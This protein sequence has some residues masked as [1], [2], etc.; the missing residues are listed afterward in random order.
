M[1]RAL[2][3]IAA[4]ALASQ[5]FAQI[6]LGDTSFTNPVGSVD[7]FRYI[8]NG[9][10]SDPG[11]N[12][13]ENMR[14]ERPNGFIWWLQALQFNMT[15][16]VRVIEHI[17][18]TGYDYANRT[19]DTL[20]HRT[21]GTVTNFVQMTY[22]PEYL[23]THVATGAD[24]GINEYGINIP[25]PFGA[26]LSTLPGGT[27]TDSIMIPAQTSMYYSTTV[28]SALE[29]RIKLK[30]FPTTIPTTINNSWQDTIHGTLRYAVAGYVDTPIHIKTEVVETK[31]YVGYGKLKFRKP[32]YMTPTFTD[33]LEVLQV[34]CSLQ[35]KDFY[36]IGDNPA[37]STT[38]S[39]LGVQGQGTTRLYYYDEYYRREGV[40]PVLT[41]RFTDVTFQIATFNQ[42]D[43][44]LRH[45]NPTEVATIKSL[46][47]IS[48]YP[49]PVKGGAVTVAGVDT[50]WNYT[51]YNI[52]GQVLLSGSVD[53]ANNKVQLPANIAAGTYF[54]SL[55]NENESVVKT[56]TIAE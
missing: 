44:N 52:N 36:Y 45:L 39:F 35:V 17:A 27:A 54:M 38:L 56:L 9:Y 30:F 24:A 51:L 53:K 55:E 26:S 18:A 5:G 16:P 20:N 3:S 46:S 50:K 19:M 43:A 48:V 22:M 2:L 23:T 33:T 14:L 47:N 7:S 40:E 6:T 12:H 34:R 13:P 4:I 29:N 37:D 42:S 32:T 11:V 28:G 31:R 21:H 10:N 25:A 15:K 49:N 1:K 8:N 41:M